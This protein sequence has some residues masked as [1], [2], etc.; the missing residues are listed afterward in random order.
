MNIMNKTFRGFRVMK[1]AKGALLIVVLTL[2]IVIGALSLGGFNG[3]AFAEPVWENGE[4]HIYTSADLKVMADWVNG[5]TARA[6]AKYRL[7]DDIDLDGIDV[8]WL[9]IGVSK[10]VFFK[11]EFNGGGYT[12]RN[13]VISRDADYIGLFGVVSRDTQISDIKVINFD[14]SN[15]KAHITNQVFVSII[16]T[17]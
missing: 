3:A 6:G 8:P 7:M 14:V 12:I 1:C 16:I 13:F 9:P 17:K 10:T 4:Y 5:S 11:G 15:I 2:L